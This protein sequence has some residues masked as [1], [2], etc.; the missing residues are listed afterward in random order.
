MCMCLLYN[1]KNINT[2]YSPSSKYKVNQYQDHM[3][4]LSL[5]A[6]I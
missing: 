3:H 2:I 4:F 5:F 6:E 1:K